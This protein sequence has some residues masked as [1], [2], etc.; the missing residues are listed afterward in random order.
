MQTEG[1]LGALSSFIAIPSVSGDPACKDH[2]WNA[3]KFLSARLEAIGASVKLATAVEGQNPVVLARL[4]ED[5]SKPT[6]VVYGHYDVQ[7]A[8]HK[9]WKTDPWVA[10]SI[11][12]YIY[13]RGTTDDKGP[14]LATIFAVQQLVEE[15]ALSVNMVFIYEGDQ[16]RSEGSS[17]GLLEV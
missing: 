9:Y 6:V 12:G 13:G 11:D 16:E 1:L 7:P 15:N 4:G 10:T 8:R 2:C 3:S 14:I 5:K 17:A